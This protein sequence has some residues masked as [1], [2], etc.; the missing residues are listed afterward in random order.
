[1]KQMLR[2]SFK[3]KIILSTAAILIVLVAAL[4]VFQSITFL[5]FSGSLINQKLD[6]SI[7]SLNLYLDNETTN[8][9]KAAV[10][11]ARQ[12]D[13]ANLILTGDT[14]GLVALF[15]S[16]VDLYQV[17]YFT[18][19]DSQGNV[20][21]RT[22]D[23]K[24]SGDSVLG[25]QTVVDA[26]AGKISSYYESDFYSKVLINTAAPVYDQYNEL[27]GTISASVALDTED[28][29]QAMKKH[30]NAEITIFSGTTRIA[31]TIIQNNKYIIGTTLDEQ[32]AGIVIDQGKTY[33]GNA[34]IMNQQYAT[35][36]KPLFGK[37]Q[38]T[39]AVIF[40]GIPLAP[41]TKASYEGI[42]IGVII[43]L[44]GLAASIL[45]SFI[46]V[47][48]M[49]RPLI[50]LS[51]EMNSFSKGN[52]K[53]NIE[54]KGED[55]IGDLSKS[56]KRAVET[57]QRLLE[58]INHMIA[59]QEMGNTEQ[60]LDTT[61]FEGDYKVL[62]ENI[63]TLSTFGMCD[64]LTGLPNRRSFNNRL[65]LEWSRALR[66]QTN[67]SILMMDIDHFKIFNDTYGHQLGDEVLKTVANVL[68]ASIK[69]TTD[70][71]ARWGGEEF[72]VVLLNTNMDGAVSVAERIRTGVE[73]QEVPLPN[74]KFT[75]VTISI[76]VHTQVPTQEDS[77]TGFVERSDEA[78]YKAKESGRNQVCTS[79]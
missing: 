54:T 13:A 53:I 72:V 37:D 4:I 17:S 64:Q 31:T 2:K 60:K 34:E 73:A 58:G 30:F 48:S 21:A 57:I 14:G 46:I 39:F 76:G 47:S 40:L 15:T 1:M 63:V 7:N 77:F 22:N 33:T 35:Y 16:M 18:I 69:R 55:E 61:E 49:S 66:E 67:L 26:L 65:N 78:L 79:S 24:K 12:S 38:K 28:V 41:L 5:S 70:F 3:R 6:T 8:T 68:A 32:I 50:Q 23:P 36:Y 62:A 75:K 51:K 19:S 43:G 27:I 29:A 59:E 20:L 44:I 71:V 9:K 25:Q 74:G 52:L 11:M 56:L 45:L 10:S 42:I